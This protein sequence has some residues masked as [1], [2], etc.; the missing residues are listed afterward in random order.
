MKELESEQR[1]NE[2]V[3]MAQN[4]ERLKVRVLGA[5]LP[6]AKQCDGSDGYTTAGVQMR[7]GTKT[8]A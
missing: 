5:G 8:V 4:V 1:R 7:Y 6:C 2:T 3:Q